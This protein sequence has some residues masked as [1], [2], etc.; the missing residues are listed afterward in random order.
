MKLEADVD[1]HKKIVAAALKLASDLMTNKSVRRKR[2]RDYDS[3]R[4]RLRE[5]EQ[6]LH[7][8]RLSSSK[9]DLPNA[10]FDGKLVFLDF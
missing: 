1:I 7:Q 2:R 6:R 5:L 3:A 9:P 4:Q 8:L 10:N